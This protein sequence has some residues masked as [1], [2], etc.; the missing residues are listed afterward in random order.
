[1]LKRFL[2]YFR[3]HIK[4]FII[5]TIAAVTVGFL[6]VLFPF[7]TSKLLRQYIPQKDIRGIINV[8]LIILAIYIVKS[9]GTWIRLYWGHVFGVRVEA[10]MRKELFNH[11]QKLSFSYFDKVKTAHLMSRIS[12]DLNIISEVAHHAPEDFIISVFIILGAI[13]FM[14]H[15]NVTLTLIAL[16]PIPIM[17]F[18]SI[19]NG[20]KMKKGFSLVRKEIA[21]INSTVENSVQGIREVKSYANEDV[22]IEKFKNS[23]MS[24]MSAKQYMYKNIATFFT[25]MNLITD[26]YYLLIVGASAYLIFLEK[27]QADVMLYF[28]MYV[29]I[30]LRPI[31]RLTAFYEQL[32]DGSASF[33]RFTEILDLNPD[34]KDK[35]NAINVKSLKGH[36]KISN[37]NF[38]YEKS[39]SIILENINIE[40]KNGDKIALVGESG[41]GKSTLVSLLPRFYEP[42]YGQILIDNIDITNITQNS[43]RE[44]IGIV[45]QNVFLFDDTIRNNILYGK[46]DASE[47]DV[48]NAAIY[49]NIWDYIKS[50]PEGLDTEVGERGVR[51]SG[52]QKQR[53]SI[54]RVFL[55]NPSIL[56]FDEATS[57]LD[58]ESESLIQESMEKL[59]IGRTTI[60]IAHRLST[61]RN[62]DNI[63]VMNKGKIIESGNHYNLIELKGFYFNL[64]NK[65]LA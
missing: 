35:E 31:E 58:T 19:K 64:Y 24:F 26:L 16:I 63:F 23:N 28:I 55:K 54:A 48:I 18:W 61:V 45:Q 42:E 46:P 38:K 41:A 60:I 4:L 39:E 56:I 37:L 5:D 8:I 25:G 49:A 34:I 20:S 29:N 7:L 62:A 44:N 21:D 59:S 51:L 14:L 43:L 40:I 50:L 3:P 11:L 65:N 36:I 47:E 53:I 2:S 22:E 52:G 15:Y 17:L 6:S 10:D 9:I 30:I 32:Q 33:E 13:P 1:M 27:I 57:S 12:N